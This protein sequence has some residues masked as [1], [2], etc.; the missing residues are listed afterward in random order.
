MTTTYKN[1]NKNRLRKDRRPVAPIVFCA[2]CLKTLI[3]QLT[4]IKKKTNELQKLD[5][6][7]KTSFWQKKQRQKKR[8]DTRGRW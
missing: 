2:F 8:S 4:W 5:N 7:N 6:E 3:K 1:K